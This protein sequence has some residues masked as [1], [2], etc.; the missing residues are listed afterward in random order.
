M[1]G[2]VESVIGD[3]D[4]CAAWIV[5]GEFR[6][7]D[8]RRFLVP[9]YDAVGGEGRVWSPHERAQVRHSARLLGEAA[10]NSGADQRLRAHYAAPHHGRRS[11]A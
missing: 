4:G 11:A 2:H 1:L 3:G 9:A 6:L 5:I 8:R 10:F 7:G